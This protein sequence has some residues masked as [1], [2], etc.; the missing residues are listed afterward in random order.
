M[1]LAKTLRSGLIAAF[2]TGA[3]ALAAPAAA[4]VVVK[5]SG[6]SA[7][8]FPVGKKLK[9]T[10]RITLKAGD[11]VT[12]LGKNGTRVLRGA[13]RYRVG[14][15]G[16]AKP[17]AFANLTRSRSQARTGAARTGGSDKVLSPNLWYVDVT[18][19]GKMCVTDLSNVTLW[20]PDVEKD[21]TIVVGPAS[22]EFTYPI[23]FDGQASTRRVD[24][25]RLALQEAAEYTITGQGAD[26]GATVTFALLENAP[27]TAE[28]MAQ[29]LIAQGC[30]L[31]LDLLAQRLETSAA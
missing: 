4:D 16:K 2:G 18:K 22:A 11:T 12:I 14:A 5:S 31:Q 19:S 21:Q 17:A 10:E 25:A 7:K 15:R 24:N 3:F 30:M 27:E 28:D 23:R 1:S 9:S 26:G 8:A 20:R 29:A 13:G 6:P